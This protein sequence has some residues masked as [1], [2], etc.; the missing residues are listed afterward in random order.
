MSKPALRVWS[1]NGVTP[2]VDPTAFVHPSAV[3]IGDVLVGAGCYVGP[4]ACLRGDFGRL[5]LRRGA[6]VQDCCVLHGFPGTDTIVEEDGH[7]GHGAILHGCVVGRNALVGMNAVVNDNAVIGESAIVAAMAFVKAGMVVP[8]RTLVAGIPARVVRELT[9]EEMAWKVEG[10]ESYQEL[11]RRSLATMV[12]TDP[13]AAP[14]TDRRRIELPE[15][16]PLSVI[17]AKASGP[18]PDEES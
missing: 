12:E 3:L 11:T 6:N 9:D 13:L 7:I 8:G 18:N 14:E 10:T 17:K 16:L 4:S 5:E 1:I 2:V 15:L